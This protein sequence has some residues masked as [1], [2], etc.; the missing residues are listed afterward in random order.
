MGNSK[1]SE[2]KEPKEPGTKPSESTSPEGVV[3]FEI[4][5]ESVAQLREEHTALDMAWKNGQKTIAELEEKCGKLQDS[6]NT[7]FDEYKKLQKLNED[8][9]EGVPC[10]PDLTPDELD[11]NGKPFGTYSSELAE[12]FG[13]CRAVD[14]GQDPGYNLDTIVGRAEGAIKLAFSQ[15]RIGVDAS[16]YPTFEKFPQFDINKALYVAVWVDDKPEVE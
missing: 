16:G 15:D 13:Y 8:D 11:A 3:T 14:F 9:S 1:P 7:L 10:F 4:T 12:G 2:P 6:L 5:E